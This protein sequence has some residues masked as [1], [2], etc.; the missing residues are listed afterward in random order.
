MLAVDVIPREKRHHTAAEVAELDRLYKEE[1]E[2][3]KKERD[4]P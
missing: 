2:R 1:M 3:R 4:K